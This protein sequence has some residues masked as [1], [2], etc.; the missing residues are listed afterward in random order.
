M[1]VET[2][3]EGCARL[4]KGITGERESRLGRGAKGKKGRKEERRKERRKEEKKEKTTT[5]KL[6]WP[7]VA[8][9]EKQGLKSPI[10]FLFQGLREHFLG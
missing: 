8:L 5:T 10:L 1:K 6:L 2:D 3:L 9:S 4:S 7:P